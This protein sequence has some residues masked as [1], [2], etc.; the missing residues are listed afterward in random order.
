MRKT[1][2]AIGAI[3]LATPVVAQTAEGSPVNATAMP[4]QSGAQGNHITTSPTSS[5]AMK[6]G[7]KRSP[8]LGAPTESG[9]S[10]DAVGSTPKH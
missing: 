2:I 5:S 1:M 10:S 3:L 8:T 7:A 6:T 9:I 4:S